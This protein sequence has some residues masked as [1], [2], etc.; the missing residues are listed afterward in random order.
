M[1]L[2]VPMAVCRQLH[3]EQNAHFSSINGQ[4]TSLNNMMQRHLGES[5]GERRRTG[6]KAE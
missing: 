6:D 1:P 2:F 3:D 4:L 5:E